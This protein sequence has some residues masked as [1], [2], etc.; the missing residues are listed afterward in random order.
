[1]LCRLIS[2]LAQAQQDA[3]HLMGQTQSR[4]EPGRQYM[5]GHQPAGYAGLSPVLDQGSRQKPNG[6]HRD[7]HTRPRSRL[8]ERYN[9]LRVTPEVC[10]GQS[11]SLICT[12]LRL[13]WL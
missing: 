9:S 6:L 8:P 7:S 4:T 11:L 5:N 13:S 10:L 12:A 1:M 3:Q 2:M